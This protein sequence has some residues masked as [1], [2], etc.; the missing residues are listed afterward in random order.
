MSSW[1]PTDAAD[2]MAARIRQEYHR[3]AAALGDNAPD[4]SE[5]VSIAIDAAGMISFTTAQGMFA[6]AKT[7]VAVVYRPL[8]GGGEE[9]CFWE[10]GEKIRH[11]YNPP[12]GCRKPD[13]VSRCPLILVDQPTEKV[14]PLHSSCP[15]IERR[16][17]TS[18]R[19]HAERPMGSV[20]L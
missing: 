16:G 18:W 6:L 7:G 11:T 4:P 8:P 5:E 15:S 20:V 9:A 14:A 1:I 19:L 10:N 2:E 3:L 12:C 17:D 13:R